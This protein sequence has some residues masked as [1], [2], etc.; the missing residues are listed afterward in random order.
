MRGMA[1]KA[2]MEHYRRLNGKYLRDA[3]ALLKK[4]DYQQASEKFWGACAEIVKAAAAK[5]EKRLKTHEELWDFVAELDNRHPSLDLGRDFGAANHLHA[6]FY[7][8]D[9]SPAAVL[10]LVEA[11]RDFVRKMERFV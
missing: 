3:E 1:S 9:L 8:E 4:G 10:I 2:K 11:A 7:E 6:N 5:K